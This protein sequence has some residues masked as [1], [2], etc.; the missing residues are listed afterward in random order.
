MASKCERHSSVRCWAPSLL[1][2][3][4]FCLT[5]VRTTHRLTLTYSIPCIAGGCSRRHTVQ[6]PPRTNHPPR[7]PDTY[8]MGR[9]AWTEEGERTGIRCCC[10]RGG[11]ARRSGCV[12]G[13]ARDEHLVVE[14]DFVARPHVHNLALKVRSDARVR[15]AA[16]P[17]CAL[18]AG[19]E[20]GG[21]GAVRIC[22]ESLAPVSARGVRFG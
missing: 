18:D 9:S 6:W 5:H 1:L 13:G 10:G 17:R 3:Q 14:V 7:T 12:G 4:A 16:A 20:G 21:D 2:T 15:R 19:A 22:G 11:A 8:N